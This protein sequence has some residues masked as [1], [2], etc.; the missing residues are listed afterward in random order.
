MGCWGVAWVAGVP[1]VCHCVSSVISGRSVPADL[2]Q[3]AQTLE[4]REAYYFIYLYQGPGAGSIRGGHRRSA[5]GSA[6]GAVIRDN[7]QR[8]TYHVLQVLL[9]SGTAPTSQVALDDG[10]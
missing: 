2:A 4:Q 1:V 7:R 9:L 8:A 6:D 5:R 10:P 3:P